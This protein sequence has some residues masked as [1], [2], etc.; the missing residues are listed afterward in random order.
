MSFAPTRYIIALTLL[1]WPVAVPAQQSTADGEVMIKGAWSRATDAD[2]KT[3]AIYFTLRNMGQTTLDLIGVRAGRASIEVLHKTE[4]G[5][6][7]AARMSATP[8]MRVAPGETL[9]LEPGGTHVM[10]IDIEKP[11]I[12]GEVLPV[13]LNFYDGDDITINVPVLAAN[14]SG[15][16]G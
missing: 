3:G 5:S 16:E 4:V 12:T 8:E 15:P 10:L 11:L 1:I 13:R 6:D 14:A 2:N 9:T 7:G